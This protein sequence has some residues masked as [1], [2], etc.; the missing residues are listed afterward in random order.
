MTH[1]L[2]NSIF[3]E[4][5]KELQTLQQ[6]F[7]CFQTH[8]VTIDSNLSKLNLEINDKILDEVE[9]ENSEF[10]VITETQLQKYQQLFKKT[11]IIEGDNLDDIEIELLDEEIKQNNKEC[12]KKNIIKT[13]CYQNNCLKD[14][15]D[16]ERAFLRNSNFESLSK[17]NQDSFLMGYLV[18]SSGSQHVT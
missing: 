7:S 14:K 2:L 1:P 16:I 8:F 3:S 13:S 6:D 17:S 10:L 12:F 15:I 9:A 4:I 5:H 11:E 18:S